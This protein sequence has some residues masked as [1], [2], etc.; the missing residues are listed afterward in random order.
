MFSNL[1]AALR[2]LKC[3]GTVDQLSGCKK[4]LWR[5]WGVR[6]G[7]TESHSSSFTYLTALSIARL[8]SHDPRW[9]PFFFLSSYRYIWLTS[10]GPAVIYMHMEKEIKT[11]WTVSLVNVV[12]SYSVMICSFLH[13]A[14]YVSNQF[15]AQ[16]PA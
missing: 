3:T 7:L 12:K 8:L 6:S 16:L 5:A 1:F 14:V 13:W 9:K 10:N 11:A 4:S 15:T 2:A